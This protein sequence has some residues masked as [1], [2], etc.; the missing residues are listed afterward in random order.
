M[1]SSYY[2]LINTI[3]IILYTI[4]K[5]YETIIFGRIKWKRHQLCFYSQN[6][7]K[8]LSERRIFANYVEFIHV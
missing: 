4:Q 6:W 1:Y 7:S 8:N 2:A 5:R 3:I